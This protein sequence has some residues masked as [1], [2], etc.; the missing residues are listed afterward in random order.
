MGS[1]YGLFEKAEYMQE[2][3]RKKGW[4]SITLPSPLLVLKDRMIMSMILAAGR[5]MGHTRFRNLNLIRSL[6]DLVVAKDT[7]AD[8]QERDGKEGLVMM[9]LAVTKQGKRNSVREKLLAEV[10]KNLTLKTNCFVSRILFDTTQGDTPQA[11]GVEYKLGERIYKASKNPLPAIPKMLRA[12]ARREVIIAAGTFNTPQLLMLSGIGPKSELESFASQDPN[13]KVLVNRPGV[14]KN[15]Q[16]R[17]EVGV[18]TTADAPVALIEDCKFEEASQDPCFAKWEQSKGVY[19][20]NGGIIGILKKSRANLSSPDFFIFL[21][22]ADFR[23]YYPGYSQ[24]IAESKQE[25]TWVILKSH[26]HNR[27]GYVRLK[28]LDPTEPPDINFRYYEDGTDENG[29]STAGDVNRKNDDLDAVVAGVQFVRSIIK[30]ANKLYGVLKFSDII[31]DIL[32]EKERHFK[33]TVPGE[34]TSAEPELREWVRRHSWGHHACGT[35]KMGR[36]DD[37]MAVVDTK[38]RVIGTKG[39]RIVD[40]SIFP[41]IP[42]YFIACSIYTISERASD[43]I[44]EDAGVPRRVGVG[45]V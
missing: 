39:L 34:N 19:A 12:K 26:S 27:G 42:G 33:E 31:P 2:P 6:V 37:P 44:L 10:G 1:Y 24:R 45:E 18:V 41:R 21:L 36:L 11:I 38:F 3:N 22:P 25:M 7:N 32:E 4:L 30:D 40:A 9:P 13:Y 5:S 8:L 28:S 35:C 17:Y 15:M 23:G 43:E 14:G 29:E 16:D 20:S